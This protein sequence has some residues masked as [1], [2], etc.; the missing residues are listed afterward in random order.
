MKKWPKYSKNPIVSLNNGDARMQ[1]L[2][3]D[4]LLFQN[5]NIQLYRDEG[6]GIS[7]AKGGKIHWTEIHKNQ[8]RNRLRILR[9]TQPVKLP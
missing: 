6:F 8:I 5:R 4:A 3:V 9:E 7:Y 2:S 1:V